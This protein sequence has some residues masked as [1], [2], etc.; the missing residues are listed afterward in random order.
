MKRTEKTLLRAAQDINE[1]T[2]PTTFI[3]LPQKNTFQSQEDGSNQPVDAD[4]IIIFINS[5]ANS[6][7]GVAPLVGYKEVYL[8][9]IDEYTGMPVIPD[10]NDNIY[11]IPIQVSTDGSL[12]Q[13]IS[14]YLASGLKLIS[15]V[16]S[17]AGMV[18]YLGYPMPNISLDTSMQSYIQEIADGTPI[19]SNSSDG[20]SVQSTRGA[21]LRE[22]KNFFAKKDPD[23]TFCRLSRVV[24]NRTGHCIWTTEE[25]NKK[26]E[27]ETDDNNG[28]IQTDARTLIMESSTIG[29]G[30]DA[31]MPGQS[32][33]TLQDG[34]TH[35]VAFGIVNTDPSPIDNGVDVKCCFLF[36]SSCNQ[37]WCICCP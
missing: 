22:L 2:V 34:E 29:P 8:Y 37:M 5:L 24:N 35:P 11:P 21:A 3:I 10:A 12:L 36:C 7:K 18:T 31:N 4:Q 25:N 30:S 27:S 13:T 17:I 32:N 1:V 19:G 9:L 33:E 23:N 6:W 26:M 28:D 20:G 14:P 16:N 15:T